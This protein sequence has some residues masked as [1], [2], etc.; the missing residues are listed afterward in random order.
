MSK[1]YFYL[2]LICLGLQ[3]V[4][5]ATAEVVS[6]ETAM[7]EMGMDEKPI[8]TNSEIGLSP[9]ALD[10][11]GIKSDG[12]ALNADPS[13]S[14]A[15]LAQNPA[16]LVTSTANPMA[17]TDLLSADLSTDLL[18]PPSPLLS[19]ANPEISAPTLQT[20]IDALA[21]STPVSQLQ[22]IDARHWAAQALRQLSQRYNCLPN[23]FT[24]EAVLTRYEFADVLY[25]CMEVINRAILDSTAENASQEDLA[26][27]Q[28]LQEEFQG[29]LAELGQRVDS[30]EEQID[31]L[32][33]QQFVKR[34]TLFGIAEF[35][36]LDTFGDSLPDQPGRARRN[37][38][39][40]NTTFT[41]GNLFLDID[42]KVRGK[43][44]I[45][46]ELFVTN[47]PSNNR[48]D[49][50]TDMTRF[51]VLP[52]QSDFNLNYLFYQMK[53]AK[54]GV[55]RVGPIGLIANHIIPDLSPTQAPSRFGRRNPIY[56]PAAG[57]GFLANYQVNDW[58]GIGAGYTVGGSDAFTPE[59]G[60]FNGQNR[61]IAQATF[62]PTPKLGLG[63]TYSHLYQ[64]AQVPIT[65][66]TG[67]RN[68][69]APFGDSTATTAHLLSFSGN[70][71]I[72]KR[73]GIGGWIGYN[74]ATAA[75]DARIC[76]NGQ[77]NLTPP[78]PQ[79]VINCNTSSGNGLL[80][81]VA[82]GDK[83]DIWNWAIGMTVADVGR[84]GNELGFVFGM[85]PKTVSNDFQAFEDSKGTSYH[86]E[87][88]YIYRI[89]PRLSL[90]P[91]VY[92]VFNPEHN[93]DNNTLV[94]ALLRT[95]MRF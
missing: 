58:L 56:R 38:P 43:D 39:N 32:E 64:H 26:V 16:S 81:T 15:V 93:P 6:D 69:Q 34:T 78:S 2:I 83:A 35:V 7:D 50:G 10:A 67:S 89:N 68:A 41:V 36:A 80:G 71:R 85:P 72:N 29:E 4:S 1:S 37:P 8:V 31:T 30:L 79:P 66:R 77:E 95:S 88:Y 5:P 46:T 53:F 45:R 54:R 86:A 42:A 59:K 27:V 40:A 55:L 51:D 47:T 23:Y 94:V 65:G 44:F 3:A 73:L 13:T 92:A 91:G 63:L 75:D 11:Q 14:I 82:K 9:I 25:T 49:T 24:E 17:E 90:I 74:Q 18:I 87:M 48:N 62:T 33:D 70:Y 57:G 28:R 12:L 21:Q 60:F 22:D 84:K 76:Q 19:Q 52:E 20:A 61:F